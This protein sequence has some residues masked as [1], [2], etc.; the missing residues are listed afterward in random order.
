M[1]NK[2]SGVTQLPNGAW[3]YRIKMTLPNGDKIDT[4]S[5]KNDN[6][7]PYLT[8]QEAREAKIE[9]EAKLK[10]GV[11]SDTKHR[12]KKATLG[13]I[14][15]NYKET[16]AKKKAPSTLRKQESMWKEHISKEFADKEIAK[17]TLVDLEKFL[18]DL[19]QGGYAYKYVEGFLKFFYLLY[20]HAYKL[21]RIDPQLY[22]RMFVDKGTRLSMPEMT[23]E[24]KIN[25]EKPAVVYHDATLRQLEEIFSGEYEDDE[26]DEDNKK[27]RPH[28]KGES[29]L[30]TAFYLGLYCG[31]RI[32]EVFA[33][34][35][36]DI[37]WS[38][39]TISIHAQMHSEGSLFYLAPVKTL[40]SVRKVIIP[41]PLHQHLLE[42]YHTQRKQKE[43]FGNAYRN[44]EI[45]EDRTNRKVEIIQG[46]DFINRKKNGE[47]LTVNSM[48]YYSKKIKDKLGFEFKFHN[49]RHTFASTCAINNMH[50]QMLM[51]LMGHKK[52]ETTMKYY[53]NLDNDELKKRTQAILDNMYH[54]QPRTIID[55]KGNEAVVISND[56]ATVRRKQRLKH[57]PR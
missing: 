27:R 4:T 25:D 32:S 50:S 24:D 38:E 8:A 3:Q 5:K 21:N 22:H 2:Y 17:I 7:L 54:Y 18:N 29:N 36:R 41:E 23:Q 11:S 57:I 44:T 45:V 53:I 31:L 12:P 43:E 13:Y 28:N 51:T 48:K 19:Y 55:D 39:L 1:A 47:L 30:L 34:R 9:H 42:L 33:L 46:G 49:L 15:N 26:E 14:Y 56:I 16:L 35:W 40:T 10:K 6:G 37:D 20:G 52:I